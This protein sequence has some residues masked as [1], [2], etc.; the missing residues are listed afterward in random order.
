MGLMGSDQN[1]A[2]A[3]YVWEWFKAGKRNAISERDVFSNLRSRFPKMEL[4]R[5]ALKILVERGYIDIIRLD[6]DLPGRKPSPLI[7][8]RPEIMENW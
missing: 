4:L 2:A 1:I 6:N 8:V 5:N 3:K 7:Y